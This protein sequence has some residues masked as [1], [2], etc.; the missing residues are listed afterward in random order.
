MPTCSSDCPSTS[1][2]PLKATDIYQIDLLLSIVI[3]I[4][5]PVPL[6]APYLSPDIYQ[7]DLLLSKVLYSSLF[8]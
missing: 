5:L 3:C 4:F 2:S 1:I 6:I 8:L 7:I